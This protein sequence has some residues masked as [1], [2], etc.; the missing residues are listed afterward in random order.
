VTTPSDSISDHQ[1]ARKYPLAQ[2][3]PCECTLI[4]EPWFDTDPHPPRPTSF[5]NCNDCGVDTQGELTH[6]IY[7]VK[8]HVWR[9]SGLCGCK[10][11]CIGCLEGRIGRL[12]DS[13]DFTTCPL[14][15]ENVLGMRP[16]TPRLLHRLFTPHGSSSIFQEWVTDVYNDFYF[17]DR[18]FGTQEI[19]SVNFDDE[20]DPYPD[21][22]RVV[23]EMVRERPVRTFVH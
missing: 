12:L 7:M 3:D 2:S 19:T 18:E 16:V 5:C 13:D 11:L 9:K 17:G 6:E 4:I 15:Y 20:A 1:P 22:R 10:T 8:E 14:N 23:L 21:E